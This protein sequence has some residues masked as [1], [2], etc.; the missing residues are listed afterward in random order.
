MFERTL[1]RSGLPLSLLLLAKAVFMMHNSSPVLASQLQYQQGQ[2]VLYLRGSPFEMGFQHG[3]LL[4]EKIH[5]NIQTYLKK[6]PSESAN[7]RVSEF[8]QAVPEVLPFIPSR[9]LEEMRGIAEGSN[10]SFEDI[11]RLNLFPEMFHCCAITVGGSASHNRSLYHV[12]V[13]DYSAG[14]GLQSSAV[15]IIANPQDRLRFMNVTYAGFIGS[16]TGINEQKIAIGEIGGQGYGNWKGMPMSF[17]LRSILEQSTSCR[18]AKDF[19][20]KTPRTCEYYYVL[21]DGKNEE[22]FGCYATHQSISFLSPG[23]DYSLSPSPHYSEELIVEDGKSKHPSSLFFKQPC[24][25]L[26]VTGSSSPERY[27]VLLQR[28]ES[29][30]GSINEQILMDIIKN[31]VSRESNLHNAI[32][33]PSSLTLWVSHAGPQEE[34]AYSQPYARFCLDELQ[35]SF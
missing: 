29:H 16:V 10:S 4:R 21:S 1:T 32:F 5:Q 33:H 12:R 20:I 7:D 19:L 2:W 28:I 30:L 23:K 6:P 11:V 34:P 18:E 27:P 25:T 15:L 13:L 35:K 24:N 17:L 22:S 14:K 9:Y 3:Y 31:P 8:L 26:L